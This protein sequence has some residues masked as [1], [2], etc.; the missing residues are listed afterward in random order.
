[1]LPAGLPIS[2]SL[3]HADCR[4]TSLPEDERRRDCNTGAYYGAGTTETFFLDIG[5]NRKPPRSEVERAPI[6]DTLCFR[7]V[8]TRYM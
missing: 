8:V 4:A 1:M 5:L 3:S 7:T 6:L 2:G